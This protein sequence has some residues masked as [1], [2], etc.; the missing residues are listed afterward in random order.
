MSSQCCS[1]THRKARHRCNECTK[2]TQRNTRPPLA[3]RPTIRGDLASHQSTESVGISQRHN[4]GHR[5][6]G[7]DLG[8]ESEAVKDNCNSRSGNGACGRAMTC[9]GR[10]GRQAHEQRAH[11]Q[12]R[13]LRRARAGQLQRVEG[14]IGAIGEWNETRAVE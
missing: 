5:F 13:R 3:N 2:T 8:R 1:H 10:T 4:V 12:R 14:E 7:I 11:T 6:C 9:V